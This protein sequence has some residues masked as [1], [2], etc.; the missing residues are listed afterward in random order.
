MYSKDGLYYCSICKT[1]FINPLLADS[2]E[3]SHDSIII[4]FT[5]K[6]VQSLLNYLISGDFDYLEETVIP[7]IQNALINT[8]RAK[9][10][11]Y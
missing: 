6:E 2:C 11:D 3:K 5:R 9:D 1:A 10:F 7:K 4:S 8:Q